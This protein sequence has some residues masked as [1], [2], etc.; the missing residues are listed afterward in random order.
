MPLCDVP[1]CESARWRHSPH[2]T[3]VSMTV[4]PPALF[5]YFIYCPSFQWISTHWAIEKSKEFQKNIYF[6]LIDYA[7]A[8]DCVDHNKLWTFVKRWEYQTNLTVSWGT[9][10]Q[11]KKQQL[12]LDMEQGTCWKLGKEYIKV[13]YC[14]PAYLIYIEYNMQNARLDE[15]QAGIKIARRNIDIL[16]CTDDATLMAENEGE[17]KSLLMRVKEESEKAGLKLNIQ[18]NEGHDI[19]SHHFIANINRKGKSGS[20]DRLYFLGLQNHCRWWLQPWN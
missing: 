1:P 10:M 6:C 8:F 18:K 16:R 5:R 4:L 14:H 9:C 13:V 11:V 3:V 20:S 19:R 17:L 12:E 15:S 2:L 7:E